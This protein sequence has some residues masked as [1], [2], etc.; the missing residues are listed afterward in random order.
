V[1][2]ISTTDAISEFE[3]SADGNLVT[4]LADQEIPDVYRADQAADDVL[5]LY[6]VPTRGGASARLNADLVPGGD[7]SAPGSVSHFFAPTPDG[8]L[9]V[10]LADQEVDQR[11]EL[12]LSFLPPPTAAPP[13]PSRGEAPRPRLWPGFPVLP[14]SPLPARESGPSCVEVT[15]LNIRRAIQGDRAGIGGVIERLSPFVEVQVRFRLGGRGGV[16]DVEDLVAETWVVTLRRLRDLEPHGDHYS[17]VL[18]RF[19]GTTALYLVNNFLRRLV[20][21]PIPATDL[22]QRLADSCDLARE[23]RGIVT[24]LA[25]RELAGRIRACLARM[26]PD[27][28]EVLALR[29]IEQKDNQE[30]ARALGLRPNTVAVRYRRALEELRASIPE[31]YREIVY[32]AG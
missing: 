6:A 17:G 8:R 24:S 28:R 26:S 25:E 21:E 2:S 20:H 13:D 22:G 23:T 19:L 18:K 29:L 3:I 4:Y 11:F 30:I 16:Q 31:T 9:V 15:T 32:L 12:F 5:E 27:K 7:V 10:Y 1:Q 14:S